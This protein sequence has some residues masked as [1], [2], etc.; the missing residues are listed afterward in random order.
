MIRP[1]IHESLIAREVVNTILICA[2]N[3]KSMEVV[4]VHFDRVLCRKALFA[5]I[6]IVS[7]QFLFL[8]VYRYNRHPLCQGPLHLYIDMAELRISVGMIRASLSLPI[9]L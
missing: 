4:P 9:A 6:I 5:D 7:E 3:L 2:G 1:H 8:G